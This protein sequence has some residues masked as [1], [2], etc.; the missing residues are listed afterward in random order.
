M[1]KKPTQANAKNESE[2]YEIRIKGHLDKRWTE[3]FEGWLINFEGT[4]ETL[5]IGEVCD[6]SALL[7]VLKTVRDSGMSLLSI[8]RMSETPHAG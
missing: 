5:L 4:G 3:R 7:G 1:D 6:Q 2:R 8:I